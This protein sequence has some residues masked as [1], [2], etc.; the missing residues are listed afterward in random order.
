[1]ATVGPP[2]AGAD[3]VD[4]PAPPGDA[5]VRPAT[6]SAPDRRRAVGLERLTVG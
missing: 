3:S 5:A 1:M 6:G 2:R 4:E